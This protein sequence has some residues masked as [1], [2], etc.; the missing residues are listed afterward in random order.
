VD[1]GPALPAKRLRAVVAAGFGG[2]L[3]HGGGALDQY[4]LQAAG[5]G[6]LTLVLPPAIWYSAA[7]FAAAIAGVFAYRILALLLPLPCRWPP[8]PRC[9]RWVNSAS[10]TPKQSLSSRTSPG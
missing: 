8:C 6:V 4:A 10:R 2:F 9:A 7:P 3:A 1:G 5:A